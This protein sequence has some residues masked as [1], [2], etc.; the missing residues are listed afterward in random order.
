MRGLSARRGRRSATTD[1]GK[2]TESRRGQGAFPDTT[3]YRP[4]RRCAGAHDRPLASIQRSTT[5][6]LW[7]A[8]IGTSSVG[9][10]E[11]RRVGKGCVCTCGSRWSPYQSKKKKQKGK[12]EK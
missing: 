12:V 9:S 6:S 11:E 7:T 2:E 8:G 3:P 10:S 1:G 5:R 4:Y